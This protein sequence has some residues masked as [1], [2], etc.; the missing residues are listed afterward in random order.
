PAGVPPAGPGPPGWGRAAALPA[1]RRDLIS[2][3]VLPAASLPGRSGLRPDDAAA[4]SAA[5]CPW[6]CRRRCRRAAR[7]PVP[8]RYVA[9]VDRNGHIVVHCHRRHPRPAALLLPAALQ[10]G[11]PPA[12]AR[13]T[14]PRELRCAGCRAG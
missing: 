14:P 12:P 5:S 6:L 8:H 10:C 2:A 4:A 7:V 9:V 1:G 3:P 11:T 13:P